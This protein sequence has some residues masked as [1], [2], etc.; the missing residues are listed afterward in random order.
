M[1]GAVVVAII[2]SVA[3]L[4]TAIVG[5]LLQRSHGLPS[6]FAVQIRA[7]LE[8]A[9]KSLEGKADRLEQE[10]INERGARATDKRTCDARIASLSEALVERDLVIRELYRRLGLPEPQI[11]DPRA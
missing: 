9:N 7:E 8:A 6:T 10:L 11:T 5:W 4:L 3:A 1:D 2:T